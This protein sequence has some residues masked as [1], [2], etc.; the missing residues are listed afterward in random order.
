MQGAQNGPRMEEDPAGPRHW[1]A[2]GPVGYKHGT[3]DG[4]SGWGKERGA[5]RAAQQP[6]GNGKPR[7]AGMGPVTG[8]GKG[9]RDITGL[10]IK[11]SRERRESESAT[12]Q[13]RRMGKPVAM[14]W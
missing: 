3:R 6:F 14:Q 11:Q 10:G 8:C 13:P 9:E 12:Q 7:D 5:A 4:M 2:G 1:V